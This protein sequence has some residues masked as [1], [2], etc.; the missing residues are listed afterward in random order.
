MK[1]RRVLL[2]EGKDDEHVIK[3]L[4]GNHSDFGLKFDEIKVHEGVDKLLEAAPV[5]LKASQGDE[6]IAIVLDADLDLQQRWQSLHDRLGQIGYLDVPAAPASEG[7]IIAAPI[8][9]LLPRLGVW[10]MP[11]NRAGGIL[12]D[13]LHFLVPLDSLLFAYVQASVNAIPAEEV[14]FP[15]V[16]KPKA[17]IHTWLAW[18]AE[19]GKPLGTAITARY[20]NANAPQAENFLAWL[21]RLYAAEP[22]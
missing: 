16:A 19:P 20:L 13:F 5:R 22:G 10:F 8:N 17:V 1:R 21:K 6:S 18:Q 3:H 11:D 2:V 9:S 12:E 4:C 14:L 7:T 15:A